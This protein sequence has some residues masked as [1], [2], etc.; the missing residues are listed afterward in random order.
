M[1]FLSCFVLCFRVRLF[2]DALWLPAGRGL[3]TWPSFVRSNCEVVTLS[4]WYPR[5]GVVLDC[6]DS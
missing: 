3:T 2:I 4:N 1:L 5:S 6:I